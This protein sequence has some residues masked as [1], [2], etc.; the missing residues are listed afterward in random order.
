V[1]T[2]K[3]GIASYQ[4]FKDRTLAIARGE[5]KPS[6]D[7]P[8]VWFT[9]IESFAKVLSDK[10]RALLALIAETKP[11]SMNELA[12][13]TGRARSNLSRTLRTMERYGLVRFEEGSGRIRAPRV[14]YSDVVLDMPLRPA[15]IAN[16]GRA[17]KTES[18]AHL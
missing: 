18:R 3:V 2:L 13:K 15:K 12:E 9:S 17:R 14:V 4:E 10:N 7:A 16:P 11:R 1:T 6:A 5:L 8:K